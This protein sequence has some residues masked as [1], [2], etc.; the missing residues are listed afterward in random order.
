MIELKLSQG[1]KPG[2]GGILPGSKVTPTIAEARGV[3]VGQDCNSPAVH[4]A[5]DGP[6]GLVDF[7]DHM[8]ELS[9]GKPVGVKMWG[10]LLPS[11][12]P[13]MVV[14]MLWCPSLVEACFEWRLSCYVWRRV[15]GG[16]RGGGGGMWSRWFSL[17]AIWR[18]ELIKTRAA[19]GCGSA[20][21]L[22]CFPVIRNLVKE[23]GGAG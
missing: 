23:G 18:C 13:S 4:S 15:F 7:V 21:V 1:A 11:S 22:M 2:H 16:K 20:M 5:F 8:R 6:A 17:A 12:I 9:G 3:E 14:F 10:T 19:D